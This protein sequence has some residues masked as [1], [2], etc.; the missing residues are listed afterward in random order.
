MFDK[1]RIIWAKLPYPDGEC[2]SK[3]VIVYGTNV[4]FGKEVIRYFVRLNVAS[5]NLLAST[6]KLFSL[7]S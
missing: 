1:R 5:V 6:Q 3:I 7:V 4:G 2:T